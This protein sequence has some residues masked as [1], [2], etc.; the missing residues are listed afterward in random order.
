MQAFTKHDGIPLVA[1]NC[2]S[3]SMHRLASF[4]LLG[5]WYKKSVLMR[6]IYARKYKKLI[7]SIDQW[8]AS[9]L[10]SIMKKNPKHCSV[11]ACSLLSDKTTCSN[12]SFFNNSM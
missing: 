6:H 9:R 3:V 5:L 2:K 8:N 1:N 7:F 10:I 4:A 12:P 11:K